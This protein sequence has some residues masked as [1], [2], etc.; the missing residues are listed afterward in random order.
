MDQVKS[1]IKY[2]RELFLAG[3]NNAANGNLSFRK[4]KNI[5][6][7]RSGSVMSELSSRDLVNID[8]ELASCEA[9]THKLILEN[10]SQINAVLHTHS[11]NAIALSLKIKKKFIKPLDLEGLYHFP[12]I[13]VVTSKM[14]PNAPD[15]PKKILDNQHYQAVIVRGHGLFTFGQDVREAYLKALTVDNICKILLLAK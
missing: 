13:P 6:I 12:Q 4:G 9:P 8:S 2:G 10:T 5:F 11:P 14:V 7:T 3:V 15:L 1:A